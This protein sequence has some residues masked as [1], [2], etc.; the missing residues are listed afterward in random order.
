MSN[1]CSGFSHSLDTDQFSCQ[2]ANGFG[3]IVFLF[4]PS[5]SAENRELRADRPCT[6][7]TL[8]ERNF[9]CRH[10]QQRAVVIF[11]REIFLVTGRRTISLCELLQPVILRNAVIAVDD[12]IPRF[13]KQKRITRSRAARRRCRRRCSSSSTEAVE[14]FVPRNHGER[15]IRFIG[16]D[17]PAMHMSLFD[18][19][20]R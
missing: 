1:S 3:N 16:P 20:C 7:V 5:S 17:E 12:I 6:N 8:H 9:A 11:E 2:V 4:F 10:M 15:T 19:Q 18:G 13:E 14:N